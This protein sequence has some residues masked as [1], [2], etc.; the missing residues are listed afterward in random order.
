MFSNKNKSKTLFFQNNLTLNNYDFSQ[1]SKSTVTTEKKKV[2]LKNSGMLSFTSDSSLNSN[3]SFN[4]MSEQNNGDNNGD[5]NL[6]SSLTSELENNINM[7]NKQSLRT[8]KMFKSSKGCGCG[9]K[10]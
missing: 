9:K 4:F 7:L 8:L 10:R 5:N 3:S 1:K 6:F 2:T